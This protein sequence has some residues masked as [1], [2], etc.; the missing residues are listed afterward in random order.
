LP[1]QQ[2]RDCRIEEEWEDLPVNRILPLALAGRDAR[3]AR[4]KEED[5]L[6]AIK[7]LRRSQ[8][9]QIWNEILITPL[10]KKRDDFLDGLLQSELRHEFP[11]HTL[12]TSHVLETRAAQIARNPPP[13]IDEVPRA[14]SPSLTHRTSAPVRKRQRPISE[15]DSDDDY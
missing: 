12:K 4:R 14:R 15:S 1:V 9:Q 6:H 11:W 7:D 10:G 2:L 3:A 5:R 8:C 13:E